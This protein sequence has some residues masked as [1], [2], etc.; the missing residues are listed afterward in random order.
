MLITLNWLNFGYT[1][2]PANP[3]INNV[4]FTTRP[5]ITFTISYES[6]IPENDL[7]VEMTNSLNTIENRDDFR[8]EIPSQT[9]TNVYE[10]IPQ[11]E[12]ETITV[13]SAYIKYDTNSVMYMNQIVRIHAD[14]YTPETPTYKYIGKVVNVDPALRL[15]YLTTQIPADVGTINSGT[16]IFTTKMNKA[17]IG[18]IYFRNDVA[19]SGSYKIT[20]TF[21]NSYNVSMDTN[22]YQAEIAFN[23]I[24]QDDSSNTD[25]QQSSSYY[26][27]QFGYDNKDLSFMDTGK[28]IVTHDDLTP[29]TEIDNQF[30][31]KITLRGFK[32]KSGSQTIDSTE[33][34]TK[35]V[36]TDLNV[37][38]ILNLVKVPENK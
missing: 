26:K 5:V 8:L 36:K 37:N 32:N 2:N 6:I 10:E 18:K 35:A 4:S 7:V 9:P 20:L 21:R 30:K 11:A 34:I 28:I 38:G 27:H 25:N 1:T 17:I 29:Y 33:T 19:G 22:E 24:G 23:Y 13:P 16:Q 3:N 15:A 31:Y 12:T 14:D